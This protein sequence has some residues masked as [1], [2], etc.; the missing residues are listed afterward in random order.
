M[1][2]RLATYS[3]TDSQA[4]TGLTG[5]RFQLLITRLW[6]VRPDGGRGRPWDLAY[7]DRVLLIVLTNPTMLQLAALF[8][9]SGSAVHRVITGFAPHLAALLGPPPADKRE[10]WVVDG[11]LIPV[12]D[13]PAPPSPTTTGAV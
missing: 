11:T 4:W 9:I 2:L 5:P 6:E 13:R 8:G 1:R 7:A 3:A 12:H 10:P